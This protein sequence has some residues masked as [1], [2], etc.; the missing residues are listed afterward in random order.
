M[1]DYVVYNVF[2]DTQFEGNPLAVIPDATKL[3]EDDLQKIAKQFNYSETVFVYPPKDS[4][5]T[6]NLRIFTQTKELSFAGH[7]IIGTIIALSD[8]GY[9]DEMNLETEI[10]NIPVSV[11][12]G[13][14]KSASF[15]VNKTPNFIENVDY[16]EIAK[17]LSLLPNNIITKNHSPHI[18]SLGIPF[19]L[20]ELIDLY[21]LA[22]IDMNMEAYIELNRRHRPHFSDRLP[23]YAYVRTE[24]G[25][26]ARAF[27]PLS[28]LVEDP[29]SGNAA[30]ALGG[31]IS[32]LEKKPIQITLA[33]GLEMGRPSRIDISTTMQDD[34]VTSITISG[35]AIKVM[36]GQLAV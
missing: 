31:L 32:T 21:A 27:D 8:L 33:Q 15:T 28:N 5:N 24:T 1:T 18:V 4:K 10:A 34:K 7:P 20:V 26:Q 6:V 17:C 30:A 13:E 19:I 36:Q 11:T 22:K 16:A 29:A 23:T 9:P 25:F 12:S 2:T 14:V 3:N 35:A